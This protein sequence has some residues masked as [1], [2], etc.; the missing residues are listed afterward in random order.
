MNNYEL[1]FLAAI[2]KDNNS[3]SSQIQKIIKNKK[4]IINN[5]KSPKRANLAYPIEKNI[6]AD[7]VSIEF[8]LSSFGIKEIEE[9]LKLNKDIL[10]HILIKKETSRKAP[11]RRREENDKKNKTNLNADKD[12]E[13]IEKDEG[14]MNKKPQLDKIK[15]KEIDKRLDEIL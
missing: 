8:R 13:I 15:F 12:K 2:S 3:L 4:G 1:T 14:L 7:I 11:R 10:R 5:F 9:E 6:S